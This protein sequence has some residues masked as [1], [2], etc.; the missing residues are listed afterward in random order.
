MRIGVK[1][2]KRVV[3]KGYTSLNQLPTLVLLYN[4]REVYRLSA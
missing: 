3:Y 2:W 1:Y 4:T